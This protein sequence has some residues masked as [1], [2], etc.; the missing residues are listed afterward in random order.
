MIGE[1]D[2]LYVEKKNWQAASRAGDAA[3]LPH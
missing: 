1:R 3:A 2:S